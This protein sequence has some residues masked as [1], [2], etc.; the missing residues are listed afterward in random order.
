MKK[1][2]KS[3]DKIKNYIKSTTTIS[4]QALKRTDKRLV[5]KP[6]DTNK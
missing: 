1:I 6:E 3:I 2:L 4:G 5:P